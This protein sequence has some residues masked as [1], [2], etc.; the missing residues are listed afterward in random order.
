MDDRS[1][2][3]W[4]LVRPHATIDFFPLYPPIPNPTSSS[5]V[6]RRPSS[7]W[8]GNGQRS[9][10]TT[11]TMFQQ[12]YQTIVRQ[13][14]DQRSTPKLAVYSTPCLKH[15]LLRY[16]RAYL[17]T[18]EGG[19]CPLSPTPPLRSADERSFGPSVHNQSRIHRWPGG[20][21]RASE[22]TRSTVHSAPPHSCARRAR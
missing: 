15:L 22:H 9:N 5:I 11:H 21:P 16:K 18:R 13:D 8:G 10:A 12:N 2:I 6:R 1:A 7:K 17:S 4:T 20:R 14:S 3:V 19:H